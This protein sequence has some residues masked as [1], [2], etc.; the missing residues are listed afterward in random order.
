MTIWS[1]LLHRSTQKDLY[2]IYFGFFMFMQISMNFRTL[3]E[4]LEIFNRRT[5]F[6][7]WKNV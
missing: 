1:S 5:D 2:K 7:K 4:F 6:W 3:Y